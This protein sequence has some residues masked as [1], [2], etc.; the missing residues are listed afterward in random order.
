MLTNREVEIMRQN[1]RV[2]TIV[3]E[4][5]QKILAPGIT[6]KQINTLCDEIAKKHNVLCAFK[7]VYGF[8]DNI[9]ISINDVVVHGRARE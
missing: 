2:H 5:I 1:A 7:G 3:F 4:E 6:A 8:P 9:C